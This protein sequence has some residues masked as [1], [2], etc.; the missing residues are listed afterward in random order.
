[1]C[2]WQGGA[3]ATTTK[4]VKNSAVLG[5]TDPSST[6]LL[7]M[8]CAVCTPA[9]GCPMMTAPAPIAAGSF[10]QL[11]WDPKYDPGVNNE[12]PIYIPSDVIIPTLDDVPDGSDPMYDGYGPGLWTKTDLAWL[13]GNAMHW[14]FFVNT[15]NWSQVFADPTTMNA[16]PDAY[17]AFVDILKNHHPG[18]HTVDHCQ[19]G[20]NGSSSPGNAIPG[21]CDCPNYPSNTCAGELDGVESMV[22]SISNSGRTHLTRMRMPYGYP[23]A[24]G[25]GASAAAV[26]DAQLV[27]RTRAVS[28]G[29][30]FATNDADNS[31]CGCSNSAAPCSCPDES[32]GGVCC[33]DTPGCS[34]GG[35]SAGPYDSQQAQ[36]NQ[37]TSQIGARPGSG[38][39]G[40][41]LMHGVLP[42]TAAAL[43]ILF[44]PNGMVGNAG[45]RIGTVEDAVCW[46][47]GMHSWDVV[48]KINGYTGTSQR[49]PN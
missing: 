17:D 34:G 31:P 4:A 43:P 16:D 25:S 30:H 15:N 8:A 41:L 27:I 26:K 24:P 45:F 47:Y 46:K 18:N 1:M 49:G 10:Q 5:V 14:D 23:L 37:V 32:K 11:G 48:N 39:W 3:T 13:D 33:S 2:T 42:W 29:W 7:N 28:I 21:C 9:T 35:A 38:A 12:K 44:G 40:I 36:I 19:I 6:N 22:A 20:D